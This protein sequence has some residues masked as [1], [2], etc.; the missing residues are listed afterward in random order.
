MHMETSFRSAEF[1]GGGGS[2][3]FSVDPG[4]NEYHWPKHRPIDI[5]SRADW[6][7]Y[8]SKFPVEGIGLQLDWPLNEMPEQDR[9][10]QDVPKLAYVHYRWPR[11]TYSTKTLDVTRQYFSQGGA[12]IQQS[13]LKRKERSVDG[14]TTKSAHPRKYD[15]D[16]LPD[17][18]QE[19][20]TQRDGKALGQG[21]GKTDEPPEEGIQDIVAPEFPTCG[22]TYLARSPTTSPLHGEC[23]V[24]EGN[25]SHTT[26]HA[27][28]AAWPTLKLETNFFIRDLDHHQD[29]DFNNDDVATEN[30]S[31][32]FGPDSHSLVVV[33][34]GSFPALNTADCSNFAVG[35]VIMPFVNGAVCTI[36]AEP[37]WKDYKKNPQYGIQ[38]EVQDN[39]EE[40]EI[41]VCYRLQQM[42][43]GKNP[44]QSLLLRAPDMDIP[45]D[46]GLSKISLSSTEYL[47][48]IMKRNLQHILF[49][50]S[51]PLSGQPTWDFDESG[52][53]LAAPAENETQIIAPTCG[54]MSGHLFRPASS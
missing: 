3:V 29:T 41:T 54:D 48:F 23:P 38:Y 26:S 24:Q 12:V 2:G 7:W 21:K 34:R 50:C 13:K 18:S 8:M 33:H 32:F 45:A 43:A 9:R 35:L 1:L 47:D 51:I 30:Y 6:L 22:G 25:M 37:D 11:F 36:V 40:L 16:M 44:W 53:S 31:V 20:L 39:A 52:K 14:E 19:N 27:E 4:D 17:R 46:C 15:G 5:N 10:T 49:V 28:F 42:R